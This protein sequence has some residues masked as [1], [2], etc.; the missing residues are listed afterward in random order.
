MLLSTFPPDILLPGANVS[1]E[2]KCFSVG[3]RLMSMPHSPTSFKAVYALNPSIW[4]RSAPNTRNNTSLMDADLQDPPEELLRLIDKARDGYDVV[5]AIRTKRKEGPLK[6][7]SYWLYDRLL[8]ALAT[9]DIPL[10][11]GDFCV[12]GRKA[13]EAINALPERNRFVRG[14]RPWIGYRQVG[15]PYERQAR[16]IGGPKYSTGKLLHLAFDGLIN[17]SYKPLRLLM[18]TGACLAAA[19]AAAGL[20]FL[21]QY[22]TDTTILGYNPRQARGWTSLILS[23]LMLGGFQLTAMGILGEYIGRLYEESK[24]RPIYLVDRQV[25]FDHDV[26]LHPGMQSHPNRSLRTARPDREH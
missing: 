6:R 14:L 1:Q 25:N 21:F 3:H 9:V 7:C 17:F 22:V 15:V 5:Y 2:V 4:L 10:D 26:M 20:V 16:E 8:A 12:I 11:S 19:S 24:G 13:L 18:V 23:I